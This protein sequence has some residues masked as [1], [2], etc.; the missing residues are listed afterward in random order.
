MIYELNITS[1]DMYQAGVREAEQVAR[2]YACSQSVHVNKCMEAVQRSLSDVQQI[3]YQT[4]FLTHIL[5]FV[6]GSYSNHLVKCE[7]KEQPSRCATNEAYLKLIPRLTSLF[8]KLNHELEDAPT[9][10]DYKEF[11]SKIDDLISRV[12]SLQLG[13]EIL[14]EQTIEELKELKESTFDRRKDM[15]QTT[16]GKIT[17]M[18]LAGMISTELANTFSQSLLQVLG[19]QLIIQTS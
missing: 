18:V 6:K 3:D 8:L 10:D 7:H 15:R 17:D 5:V 9:T 12:N 16:L 14:F 1:Q 11:H 19:K 13:Q 4:G 2:V